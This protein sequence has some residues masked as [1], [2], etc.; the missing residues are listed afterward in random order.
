MNIGS[1]ESIFSQT[2]SNGITLL[3]F[4]D[5]ANQLLNNG[6]EDLFLK[7][8][9]FISV[10]TQ[11]ERLLSPDLLNIHINPFYQ[12]S[13]KN[14]N[15]LVQSWKNKRTV[16]ALKNILALDEPKLVLS[17]I[18]KG[19][20]SL[21][22]KPIVLTI[23]SPQKWLH[24]VHEL[25]NGD[26]QADFSLDDFERASMYFAEFLRTFSTLGIAAIVLWEKDETTFS[27]ADLQNSYQPIS[28]VANHYKWPLGVQIDSGSVDVS[29]ISDKVD[30]YLVQ[31]LQLEELSTLSENGYLIGG[32]LNKQFWSGHKEGIINPQK[33]LFFGK[34]PPDAL[35]ETVLAQLS[36]LKS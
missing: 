28:N 4:V 20:K 25:V 34:I 35:P 15:E 8:D 23:D 31:S 36:I 26:K 1:Y 10:Y 19:L 5:Y 7:P 13:I 2:K 6:K 24:K 17:E 27:Q 33:G 9:I 16:V 18:V 14:R 32:G 11:A 3:D 30:F 21:S 22:N 29:C 12:V